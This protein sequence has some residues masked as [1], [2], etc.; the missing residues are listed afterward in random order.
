MIR[1]NVLL[2][3]LLIAIVGASSCHVKTSLSPSEL[4]WVN[5]YREGDTL[6]FKSDKGEFDTTTIVKKEIFY[7]EY[8][9]IESN[10]HF[11]PQWGVV[12][13]KNKHLTYH[14]D[15]DQMV[16][17]IKKRPSA[18]T[19]LSVDYLYSGVIYVNITKDSIN[20]V[21]KGKI[22]EFDASNPRAKLAQPKTIYWHED[23][24]IIKYVT[25]DGTVWTR[26]NVPK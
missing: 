10:G 22:Y 12:W 13:Y 16:T 20:R 6:V 2:V 18:E 21:K 1:K 24:G 5:V 9:P 8:N 11:L 26:L 3:Y 25:Y 4:R 17:I 15:G 7:P 23:F 19:F 14:P